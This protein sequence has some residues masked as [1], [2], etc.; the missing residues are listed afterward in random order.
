MA[1][2]GPLFSY[3]DCAKCI[4]LDQKLRVKSHAA[5]QRKLAIPAEK[6]PDAAAAADFQETRNHL[7]TES[8]LNHHQIHQALFE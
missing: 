5:N 6:K 4:I 8:D 7:M 3:R 1:L 2:K